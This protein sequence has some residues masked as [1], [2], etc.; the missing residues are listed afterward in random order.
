MEIEKRLRKLDV[1]AEKRSTPFAAHIPTGQR[2]TK[3]TCPLKDGEQATKF[4]LAP[5]GLRIET[6][7][8]EAEHFVRV[9]LSGLDPV[10]IQQNAKEVF[11]R[12]H[13]TW[14]SSSPEPIVAEP[15]PMNSL[16]IEDPIEV[17]WLEMVLTT[18]HFRSFVL[19]Q[20]VDPP[21]LVELISFDKIRQLPIAEQQERMFLA[22][23]VRAY[24]F[25]YENFL[26][27]DTP[28]PIKSDKGP[29]Y[30]EQAED[31]L[32]H[33]YTKSSRN[34]IRAL[35]HLISYHLQYHRDPHKMF[36]YCD[37]VLR[38]AQDLELNKC[39]PKSFMDD[40]R[41]V[42]EDRR[43][44]WS[45]YWI[46]LWIAIEFN[47]PVM[48]RWAECEVPFPR[49]LP[50]EGADVGYCLDFC[51]YAVKLLTIRQRM[52]QTLKLAWTASALL[53]QIQMLEYELSVWDENLPVHFIHAN[54]K[55]VPDSLC[56]E[57]GLLL[58]G[59]LCT[60]KAQMYECLLSKHKPP[61]TTLEFLAIRSSV[62]AANR[63]ADM[64]IEYAASMR[65][66]I[67]LFILHLMRPCVM[68]LLSH[69]VFE[70]PEIAAVTRDKLRCIQSLLANYPYVQI[71]EAV[72][73]NRHIQQACAAMPSMSLPVSAPSDIHAVHS[74][75]HGNPDHSSF[76]KHFQNHGEMHDRDSSSLAPPASPSTSAS[77]QVLWRG[78]NSSHH[79]SPTNNR[80]TFR[81]TYSLDDLRQ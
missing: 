35:L 27:D 68:I 22:K 74:H 52:T 61:N 23:S 18:R 33:C 20:M 10:K 39:K 24:V 1:A 77:S 16:D 43:L 46:N 37:L 26:H 60:A 30:L 2:R 48:A 14:Q 53:R 36:L 28:Y 67:C 58:Q 81:H 54:W 69:C 31:L 9:L 72:E 66:C 65:M 17:T 38:M 41:L 45:A 80:F 44:W 75:F 15:Y 25:Y 78:L 71:N 51:I 49:R 55:Q 59:Q 32:D 64:V 5:S 62:K 47:R 7:I 29:R 12:Q 21:R 73:L 6:D 42:E 11:S 4:S 8:K 3:E 50:D 76:P 79:A 70:T 63:F 13:F 40:D 19:Y 57:L 34:S 56:V